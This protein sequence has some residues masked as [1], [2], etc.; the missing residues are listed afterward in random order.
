MLE[1]LFNF[2]NQD[3]I[4]KLIIY[5]YRKQIHVMFGSYLYGAS[6]EIVFKQQNGLRDRDLG[7]INTAGMREK[8]LNC[9]T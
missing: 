4:C 6:L 1:N 8:P 7:H 9:H 5:I 2:I 3:Q